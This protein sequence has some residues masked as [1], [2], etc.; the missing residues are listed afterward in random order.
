MVVERQTLPG[1]VCRGIPNVSMPGDVS[2][3]DAALFEVWLNR[4]KLSFPGSF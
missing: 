1:F 4:V 2:G 3:N